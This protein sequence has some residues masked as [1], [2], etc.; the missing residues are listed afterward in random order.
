MGDI[1]E[2]MISG[3]LCAMC[4]T[5]LDCRECE[6]MAIPMYCSRACARDAGIGAEQVCNH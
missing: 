3:V 6:D 4:G 1:A 2:M 5:A